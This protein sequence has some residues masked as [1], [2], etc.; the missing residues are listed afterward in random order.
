[1]EPTVTP[2]AILSWSI[3]TPILGGVL[4]L[5][6]GEKRSASSRWLA[7]LTA[8]ATF[9]ST[10]PLYSGF[11]SSTFGMLFFYLAPWIAC[12]GVN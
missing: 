10:L 11:D 7:L 1:M 9:F 3:W 6:W 8:L 2:L 12:L 4:V 5:L